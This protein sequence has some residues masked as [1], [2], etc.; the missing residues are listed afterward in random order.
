M[1]LKIGIVILLLLNAAVL[2]WQLNL[3]APWELGPD[4]QREPE[5]LQQQIRPEALRVVPA[6]ADA[7]APLP[8]ALDAASAAEPAASASPAAAAAS[9]PAS[10]PR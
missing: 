2:A 5:R 10:L 8:G 1:K 3:G 6:L 4:R 7:S 9:S